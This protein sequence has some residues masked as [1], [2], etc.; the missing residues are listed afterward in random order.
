MK[1]TDTHIAIDSL[2]KIPGESPGA[3]KGYILPVDI[4]NALPV[5]TLDI[6]QTTNLQTA[7]DT[8]QDNIDAIDPEISNLQDQLYALPD[9]FS[10][11]TGDITTL[12]GR[13]DAID[14]DIVT[15]EGRVDGADSDITALNGALTGKANLSGG[16]TFSGTQSIAEITGVDS[17][18]F[19]PTAHGNHTH[20][21]GHV[22]YDETDKALVYHTE[23][24]DVHMT[25]G[26]E[27]WVRAKNNSGVPMTNGQVVRINGS[28]TSIPTLALALADTPANARLLGICTHEIGVGEIGYVTT[29]GV[30]NDLNTNVYAPGSPLYLSSSVPGGVTATMPPA[31]NMIVRVGIVQHQHSSE[32]KVLV[33]IQV[34]STPSSGI[35][36]ATDLATPDMVVRRSETG[37]AAFNE[38]GIGGN[39]TVN[40]TQIVPGV[41]G[42][43]FIHKN[44]GS[45]NFAR[46]MDSLVVVNNRVTPDS[47]IML[48]KATNDNSAVVGAAIAG[49]GQF[50]IYMDHR[51]GAECKVNFMIFN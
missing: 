42:D 16:N 8:L 27:L 46:N 28:D 40:K 19:T 35:I 7:L 24:P 31:P 29:F 45:V 4:G 39:V 30:V 44:F 12:D 43:A 36:D 3:I 23:N 49:N 6:A 25:I 41:T 26:R 21:E 17:L 34:I 51:P 48:S 11:I 37:G 32:G 47:I 15:L 50:T 20:E 9:Q 33:D 18:V 2:T 38:L 1:F 10:A 13:V 14:T 22:F 5:G